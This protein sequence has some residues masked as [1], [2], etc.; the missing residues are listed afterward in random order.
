MSTKTLPAEPFSPE[1]TEAIVEE[2]NR[3]GWVLIPGVLSAEEITKLRAGIERMFNDPTGPLTHHWDSDWSGVRLFERERI[4]RDM[5]VREP[6]ISIAEAVVSPDCHLIADGAVYNRPGNALSN[7]HVDDRVLFPL[8]EDIP[9]FDPR[10]KIPNF[11]INFQF[12]L[13]DVPADE[14]GPT[15]VVPG[16]HYSG[17]DPN[18]QEDPSFEGRGPV[19]ILCKAGDLYLQH[20]QVWHRGAP[21]TSDRR[22]C[23]YQMAFGDRRYSQRFYPFLNYRVPDHVLDGADE[24]LLR[25]FGKHP[26]GAY[27]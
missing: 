27:G 7:W 23:L 9:R 17:R 10:I 8:P 26:K 16:T 13:T 12:M 20:S 18:S 25:V 11:V 3:E 1:K 21:N 5:I 4:F 22:R 2:F 24:R 19:S 15:Q 6:I 14:Y